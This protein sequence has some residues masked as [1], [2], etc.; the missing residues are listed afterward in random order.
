VT[1]SPTLR[2]PN[3][4]DNQ[5]GQ[6]LVELVATV[7]LVVLCGLLC[8]QALAAGSTYVY[9]DNAAHAAALGLQ[10][11]R[12]GRRAA[13]DALPGWSRGR[14]RLR[15]RGGRIQLWLTPRALFP[16][17]AQLLTAHVAVSYVTAFAC[18]ARS[19][20]GAA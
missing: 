1:G 14:V 9:A 15:Q 19:A 4:R 7:P 16:P 13:L 18:R 10:L 11:G 3:V 12:D 6:G 5:R 2:V 17:V 8:M 20:G